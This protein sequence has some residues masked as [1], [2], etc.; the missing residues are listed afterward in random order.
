MPANPVL[1]NLDDRGVATVTLNRPEVNNAYDAGLI[2]GVLAAIDELGRKPQLRVVVLKGNGKHFQAGADLKWINAVRPQSPADNEAVS[3]ATFEAVQRLNTLPIPTVALVQGGCFGG[4]T[5]IISACDVVIAADNALFSIT[6]VRWGLTAAII[7]PQLCDAIGVRQV[8]RYALTGE[9]FGAEDARRIGLVHEVVPLGE[10]EAAGGKVVEQLL[11]NGPEALAET[12]A[13]AM[14]N[15][16]GGMSVDDETYAPWCGHMRPS[17]RPRKRRK[18]WRRL[19][20]SGRRIGRA[21]R[22]WSES[23]HALRHGAHPPCR[24]PLLGLQNH[25]RTCTSNPDLRRI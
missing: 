9:R 15:S 8:R 13:L 24:E 10:L 6:E 23:Q 2:H 21:K 5:G 16:F 19:R 25:R 11:A 17:A 7:I 3:R 20:R 4:G 1:W 22:N 14:E 18:A 12:K